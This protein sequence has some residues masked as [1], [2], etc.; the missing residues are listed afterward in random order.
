MSREMLERGRLKYIELNKRFL[1][2][3]ENGGSW[4]SLQP[5]VE[6]MKSLA[7]YLQQIP[8]ATEI[9]IPVKQLKPTAD[10]AIDTGNPSVEPLS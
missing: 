8:T 7:V 6:E 1:A 10:P 5:L 2:Q 9:I 3:V 4:E